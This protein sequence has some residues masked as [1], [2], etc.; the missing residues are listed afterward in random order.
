[1]GHMNVH[2]PLVVRCACVVGTRPEIIKMAPVIRRLREAEWA[3]CDLITTGQ[4]NGLLSQG[5]GRFRAGAGFFH[6]A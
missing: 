1:M 6:S 4:H 2:V 5:L 3:T